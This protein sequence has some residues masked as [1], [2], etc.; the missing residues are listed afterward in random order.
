MTRGGGALLLALVLSLPACVR[1]KGPTSAELSHPLVG[2]RGPPFGA[3]RVGGGAFH[4]AAERGHPVVVLFWATWCEPCKKAFPQ[5]ANL[6]EK[7][8]DQVTIVAISEDDDPNGIEEF[9]ATYE[10]KFNVVW[11]EGKAFAGQWQ[12]KAMPASFLLDGAGIV[13]SVHLGYDDGEDAEIE[14]D[15]KTLL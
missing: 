7:Y 12:P 4:L 2:K 13:R 6:S 9:V 1:G 10:G 3:V 8:R 11:D 5:L 15:L 14:K